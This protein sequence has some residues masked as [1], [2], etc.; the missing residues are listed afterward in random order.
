M[1]PVP[2]PADGNAPPPAG[3][4]PPL[5][6]PAAQSGGQSAFAPAPA[7]QTPQY[8]VPAGTL[9]HPPARPP[10]VYVPPAPQYAAPKAV[11]TNTDGGFRARPDPHTPVDPL[12]TPVVRFHWTGMFKGRRAEV[13][14]GTPVECL[15]EE[16]VE[17]IRGTR[18]AV[19]APRGPKVAA[20]P[21]TP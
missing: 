12:N 13:D 4:P 7:N 17:A 5:P 9:M 1:P 19:I 21:F 16:I 20:H 18:H 3:A 11:V 2:P 8:G 6:G 14:A 15:P 10:Q